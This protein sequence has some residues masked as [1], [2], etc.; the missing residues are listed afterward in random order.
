MGSEKISQMPDA[1][2]LTG[3]ELVP[4]VQ[5]GVN[6]KTTTLAIAQLLIK[7][8][9]FQGVG[10]WDGAFIQFDQVIIRKSQGILQAEDYWG[11]TWRNK[12]TLRNI[13]EA[14]ES[15]HASSLHADDGFNGSGSY[16]NFTIVDGIITAA[17]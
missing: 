12:A 1:G 4:V 5:A 16:T 6:D 11:S 10:W 7:N 13:I 14:D 2:P 15:V 8:V 17:S 3:T 9:N